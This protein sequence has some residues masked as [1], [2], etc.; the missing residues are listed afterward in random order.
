MYLTN[1]SKKQIKIYSKGAVALDDDYYS[2]DRNVIL[3][4]NRKKI[5]IKSCE[6]KAISWKVIGRTTWYDNEDLEI[7]FKCKYKGKVS[8]LSVQG[9]TVYIWKKKK[10]KKLS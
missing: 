7:H 10:W 1:R 9:E 3:S 5:K 6:C 8:W 4:K 2:F